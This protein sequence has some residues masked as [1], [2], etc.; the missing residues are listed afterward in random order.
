MTG[1]ISDPSCLSRL[2]TAQVFGAAPSD[3]VVQAR[4]SFSAETALSNSK[5]VSEKGGG[6][7]GGGGGGASLKENVCQV[8]DLRIDV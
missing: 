6:G 1:V 7:G 2:V 5:K 4:D 8:N 3:D